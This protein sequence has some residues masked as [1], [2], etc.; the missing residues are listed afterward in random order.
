VALTDRQQSLRNALA[1]RLSRL[2]TFAASVLVLFLLLLVVVEQQIREYNREIREA[3]SARM[4]AG[5]NLATS[6]HA[7]NE[8]RHAFWTRVSRPSRLSEKSTHQDRTIQTADNDLDRLETELERL[9]T[10]PKRSAPQ[11]FPGA[12]K[13]IPAEDSEAAATTTE[14]RTHPPPKELLYERVLS[15]RFL[16]DG[17]SWEQKLAAFTKA[18]EQLRSEA[19][20]AEYA[21]GRDA[22]TYD[23]GSRVQA[24]KILQAYEDKVRTGP[25]HR[26]KIEA[27]GERIRKA[28][29][30]K[31]S[32]P[33]PL[34]NFQIDPRLALTGM[35]FAALLAYIFFNLSARG[36]RM[37]ARELADSLAPSERHEHAVPIPSWFFTR[38][39][40]VRE[41]SIQ[42][43][44]RAVAALLHA[45]WLSLAL[46][47][48]FEVWRREASHTLVLGRSHAVETS[49]AVIGVVAFALC[50]DFLIPRAAALREERL[51]RLL[52]TRLDR[53]QVI[54]AGIFGAAA[55]TFGVLRLRRR[56]PKGSPLPD[57][58]RAA[59]VSVP[60]YLRKR[61]ELEGET[62]GDVLYPPQTQKKD[63]KS[64]LTMHAR[65][66]VVHHIEVCSRHLPKPA[67]RTPAREDAVVH[68][69]WEAAVLY[70]AVTEIE[71]LNTLTYEGYRDHAYAARI[72][73]MN[74][75]VAEL[76]TRPAEHDGSKRPPTA[77]EV[78]AEAAEFRKGL[79]TCF[80]ES[81]LGLLNRQR[82]EKTIRMLLDAIEIQP[83]S[84]QLHHKLIRIYGRERQFGK[85]K[86]LIDR[87]QKLAAEALKKTPLARNILKAKKEFDSWPAKLERRRVTSERKKIERQLKKQL[88]KVFTMF[89]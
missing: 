40:S 62:I 78:R 34:G 22:P 18:E 48:C 88:Q 69:G 53:R 30:T 67:Y 58:V 73:A 38:F 8:L 87:S 24:L 56:H 84:Y 23:T 55:V 4:H 42:P 26:A 6:R 74:E 33:T 44:T 36:A 10:E 61:S 50:I 28:Y 2:S 5:R 80:N 83:W 72:R 47:I 15:P 57:A 82:T 41:M 12:A 20:S 79:W 52:R 29:A 81:S 3:V 46:I 25:L 35:A 68:H 49:L 43:S 27:A 63:W 75:R 39:E 31:Q 16:D 64:N 9:L 89:G 76:R 66:G 71:H 77:V 85:I 19:E 54:G 21:F 17:G 32:I 13:A 45:A 60:I 86:R 65:T 7:L 11:D 14:G 70:H 59:E 51:S 1:S 37:I